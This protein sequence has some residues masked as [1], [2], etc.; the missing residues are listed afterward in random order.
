MKIWY[1]VYE[2]MLCGETRTLEV[3]D[4]FKEAKKKL[5]TLKNGSYKGTSLHIDIWQNI[6]NPY[7]IGNLV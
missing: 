1:E 3:C 6:K 4:T 5:K 7:R 2:I